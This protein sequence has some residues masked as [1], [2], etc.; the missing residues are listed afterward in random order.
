MFW[1]ARGGDVAALPPSRCCT[2]GSTPGA[3]RVTGN[4]RGFAPPASPPRAL[5]MPAP[6][7]LRRC[8]KFPVYQFRAFFSEF[9]SAAMT[10]CPQPVTSL[11]SRRSRKSERGSCRLE[12]P[13]MKVSTPVFPAFNA[14]GI[15]GMG[16]IPPRTGLTQPAAWRGFS[17]R[18]DALRPL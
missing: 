7:Q 11:R 6:S 1:P 10:S 8:G 5:Q 18:R 3:L 17:C 15:E 16:K 13:G 2:P 12:P 14:H 4:V 9:F